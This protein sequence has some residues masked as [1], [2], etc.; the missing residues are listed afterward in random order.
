MSA[1]RIDVEVAGTARGTRILR[2]PSVV[3]DRDRRS[4]RILESHLRAWTCVYAED[5]GPDLIG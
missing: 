4:Q 2:D 1:L 3:S 5:G